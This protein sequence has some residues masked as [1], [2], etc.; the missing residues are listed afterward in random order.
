MGEWWAGLNGGESVLGGRWWQVVVGGGLWAIYLLRKFMSLYI[1]LLINLF[2]HLC[3]YTRSY[4]TYYTR[5][6][7]NTNINK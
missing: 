5:Q 2:A 4:P 6:R 7:G 1:Y 3:N